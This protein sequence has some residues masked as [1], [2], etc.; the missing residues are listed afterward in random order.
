MHLSHRFFALFLAVIS[1]GL[2]TAHA[3]DHAV[4]PAAAIAERYGLSNWNQIASIEFTF[5]VKRPNGDK[6]ARG[7]AWD[8]QNQQV[9][10]TLNGQSR[11][12]T[13]GQ[14]TPTDEADRQVDRQFINDSYW[15]L[16]PFQLVWSDPAVTDKGSA[17]LPIGDGQAKKV[18]TQWPD[19]G[20][21]T[22]GDAY[23]L[24]LGDDR[25][26]QQWVF[27]K[28]GKTDGG[29]A[30]TWEDH[31]QLGPIVVSLDHYSGNR[32]FRLF[33]T[34]VKATLTDGTVVTPQPIDE[35]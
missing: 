10:R 1:L 32:A 15:L 33:F 6:T 8:V 21:Y 11:T 28:G 2:A 25:L 35:P 34:D 14:G 17:P 7:W 31:R 9:T 27:R 18:V 24:Y 29:F 12:I 3:D 16:F 13:L 22:P 19:V 5:N 4:S 20:G 23:D 30:T 26:V